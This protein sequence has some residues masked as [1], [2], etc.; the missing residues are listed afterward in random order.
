MPKFKS[1]K[2][3]K[4][5]EL[6]GL[7]DVRDMGSLEKPGIGKIKSVKTFKKLLKKEEGKQKKKKG[8]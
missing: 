4:L 1:E 3:K 7:M 8:L 2:D 6:L 5:K